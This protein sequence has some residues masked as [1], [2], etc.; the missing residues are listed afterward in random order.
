MDARINGRKPPNVRRRTAPLEGSRRHT[1]APVLDASRLPVSANRP[2]ACRWSRARPVPANR[3]RAPGR[4][5]R[6][7][8]VICFRIVDNPHRMDRMG[9]RET[10]AIPARQPGASGGSRIH[11]KGLFRRFGFGIIPTGS[12][13]SV[14]RLAAVQDEKAME[15]RG[16]TV[17]CAMASPMEKGVAISSVSWI[18]PPNR[19]RAGV[20]K[21]GQLADSATLVQST[22]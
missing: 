1:T 20:K 16:C 2:R 3:P 13:A 15:S 10:V 5:V 14:R 8:G 6:R 12:D 4:G 7:G 18:I 19:M 17:T 22:Q 11:A 9:M 21:P